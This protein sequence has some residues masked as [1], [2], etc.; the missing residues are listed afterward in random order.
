LDV[1]M[2]RSDDEFDDDDRP[3]R[4]PPDDDDDLEARPRRRYDDD[5]D[6]PPARKKG[7]GLLIGILVGVFVVCCGG[8]GAFVYFVFVQAKKAVEQVNTAMAAVGETAQSQQNLVQI[9]TAAQ[10]HHDALGYFPNDSY[11]APGGKVRPLLSWR[12]HLLPYLGENALYQQFKL[13]EPWDS[14]NNLPLLNKMPAVY[15]GPEA[16]RLAGP[17]KTF[18]R[19]F[20]AP[21]GIFEKATAQNLNPRVAVAGVPDGTANTLLVVD[22]GEPVDWTKPDDLD[23]SP[24][25]PRPTFGGAYPNM[26]FALV[27][28]CDGTVH[29][30]RKDVP[31]DTLRK[32]ID[33][34]DGQVVPKNWEQK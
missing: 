18:Y 26:P 12:V 29:S 13:N 8:G 34:M 9:G 3:R 33:R 15:G 27:L 23:F 6:R 25:K 30:M 24:G 1:T 4:R 2:P 5:D 20:S 22:A 17:G 16:R 32:L 28:T 31:D 19:G 11:D 14:P 7:N 21:R 10:N